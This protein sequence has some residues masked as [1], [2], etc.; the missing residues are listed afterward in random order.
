MFHLSQAETNM[1]MNFLYEMDDVEFSQVP[2]LL[3]TEETKKM[4]DTYATVF[5]IDRED[6]VTKEKKSHRFYSIGA[7][8]FRVV[9]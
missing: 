1:I 4:L 7:S 8:F 6:A 2:T 5:L 3:F 9:V